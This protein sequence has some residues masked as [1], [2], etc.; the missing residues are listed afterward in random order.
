MLD[1]SV[2]TYLFSLCYE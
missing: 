1:G 2:Q